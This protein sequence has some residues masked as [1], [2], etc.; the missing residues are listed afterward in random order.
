[1]KALRTRIVA[2]LTSVLA[3]SVLL[4]GCGEHPGTPKPVK[5]VENPETGER[6]RFFKESWLK[7]PA[8]YDHRA[9]LAAW[10]AARTAEGFTREISPRDDA[11]AWAATQARARDRARA[12]M[13]NGTALPAPK[14]REG[15]S[16]PEPPAAR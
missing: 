14:A 5:V 4:A 2:R 3:G 7:L 1:M 12:L 6:A 8:G 16:L 9:H 13:T 10:V 11:A 15:A